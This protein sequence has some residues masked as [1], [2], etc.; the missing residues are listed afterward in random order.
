MTSP[1]P[2]LRDFV[3]GTAA[4]LNGTVAEGVTLQVGEQPTRAI[5][6]PRSDYP[7]FG[8]V[9][10][11]VRGSHLLDL[12]LEFRFR[13]T[14]QGQRAVA[15]TA[16]IAVAHATDRQP[17]VRFDYVRQRSWA[18]AHIQVH[19]ESSVLGYVFAHSGRLRPPRTRIQELHLPMGLYAMPPGLEDVI[20]FLVHNL[21]VDAAPNWEQHVARAR[22]QRR[23]LQLRHLMEDRLRASPGQ[24]ATELH[25]MIDELAQRA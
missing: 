18:P 19:G 17:L 15:E 16:E 23:V 9:P 10:L 8:A 14:E 1:P 13:L 4:L 20:E 5:V 7:R 11:R 24:A 25:A 22:E 2:A 6:G 3:S 12:M 21:G